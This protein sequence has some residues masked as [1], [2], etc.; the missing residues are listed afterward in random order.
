MKLFAICGMPASGKTTLAQEIIKKY[1]AILLSEDEW[2]KDLIGIYD[3]DEMRNNIGKLHKKIASKLLIQGI[4]IVMDGGCYSKT[5]RDDLRKIALD[6]NANFELHNLKTDLSILNS[7]RIKRNANLKSEF[8][9]TE[10]NFKKAE[11][12]FQAP[13]EVENPIIYINNHLI[14]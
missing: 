7:R 12:F 9:T 10:E 13:K 11:T 2:M 8:H 6:S 3:N 1:S 5:E 4:N 14:K